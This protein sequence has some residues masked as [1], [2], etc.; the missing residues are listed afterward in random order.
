MKNLVFVSLAVLVA[1]TTPVFSAP[2]VPNT[3]GAS[4][5]FDGAGKAYF[6]FA[7]TTLNADI[8]GNDLYVGKSSIA[9]YNTL[10]GTATF[11]IGSGANA[12]RSNP[13]GDGLAGYGVRTFGDYRTDMTGGLI[14]NLFG[15]DTSVTT[16]SGGAVDLAVFNNTANVALTND[17]ALVNNLF[18]GTAGGAEAP[19]ATVSGGVFN[20]LTLTANSVATITGGI[21]PTIAG[22]GVFLYD[23]G[24][25]ADIYGTGLSAAYIGLVDGYDLFNVTGTLQNGMLYTASAP[26]PVGVRS[27]TNTPNS[28][29]RQFTLNNPA[30]VPESGT[31]ALALPALGMIGA[32]VIRR[33][34]K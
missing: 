2:I 15:A 34:K 4:Y 18:L 25:R 11:T 3:S 12:T 17:A 13:V 30:V 24:A 22:N 21:V 8:A 9:P 7:D 14:A 23:T 32:A 20:F 28:T 29:Q 31:L 26:L 27:T 1:A 10:A 16:I 33:R 5:T 19:T 6:V